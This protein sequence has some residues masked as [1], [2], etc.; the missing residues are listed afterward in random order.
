MKNELDKLINTQG[1][2]YKNASALFNAPKLKLLQSLSR[3]I[4]TVFDE[5]LKLMEAAHQELKLIRSWAER[6]GSLKSEAKDFYLYSMATRVR[7]TTGEYRFPELTTLAEAALAAHGGA[8]EE[9]LD[10]EALRKRVQRYITRMG[11]PRPAHGIVPRKATGKS[12]S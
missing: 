2:F 1:T 8:D 7:E 11:L 4:N 5:P 6:L 10:E 3:T 12:P 9:P